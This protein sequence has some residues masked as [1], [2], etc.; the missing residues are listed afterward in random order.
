MLFSLRPSWIAAPAST[1]SLHLD[2]T[3]VSFLPV[4]FVEYLDSS[5]N[6]FQEIFCFRRKSISTNLKLFPV[7]F[8]F[9]IFLSENS[10]P[11]YN[12]LVPL[13]HLLHKPAQFL[14]P[15]HHS[16]KDVKCSYC[17]Q[18]GHI[19]SHCFAKCHNNGSLKHNQPILQE[20]ITYFS[21]GILSPHT[22]SLS[23]TPPTPMCFSRLLLPKQLLVKMTSSWTLV[24]LFLSPSI[25]TATQLSTSQRQ[26]WQIVFGDDTILP[27]IGTG[28]SQLVDKLW[29]TSTMSFMFHI[30]NTIHSLHLVWLSKVLRCITPRPANRSHSMDN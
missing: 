10:C 24:H 13:L 17:G 6:L 5:P 19:N 30:F 16:Y 22:L 15:S 7:I 18:Q 1:C 9:L 28:S 3:N 21:W 25:R 12:N 4:H 29:S 20:I 8:L 27:V 2:M 26:H 11:T 23:T 14:P